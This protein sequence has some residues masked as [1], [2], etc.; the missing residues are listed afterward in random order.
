[1]AIDFTNGSIPDGFGKI[2]Y[3]I[4]SQS[5]SYQDFTVPTW[6]DRFSVCLNGF[7]SS[8]GVNMTVQ[9][10]DNNGIRT[11]GYY[12]CGWYNNGGQGISQLNNDSRFPLPFGWDQHTMFGKIEV[13]RMHNTNLY[14]VTGSFGDSG[15]TLHAGIA[16]LV[17]MPNTVTGIRLGFAG[18]TIDAGSYSF[19][20]MPV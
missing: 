19:T 10:I 8:A 6:C 1:M 17:S 20:F 5:A 12:G 18:G 9:L 4:F 14:V 13:E 16:G 2:N 7:S 11:A 15:S 3:G